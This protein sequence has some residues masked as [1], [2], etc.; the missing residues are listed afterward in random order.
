MNSV[1]C[2]TRCTKFFC[3][4]FF[5]FLFSRKTAT[6]FVLWCC[7]VFLWIVY[8]KERSIISI[9]QHLAIFHLRIKGWPIWGLWPWIS[10]FQRILKNDLSA[11]QCAWYV[12]CLKTPA[13]MIWLAN[14]VISLS[15]QIC[16]NT[17]RNLPHLMQKTCVDVS[18]KR[19]A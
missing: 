14:D 19:G 12:C 6:L 4:S 3:S 13:L 15:S 5:F 9:S 8:F 16:Q 2:F 7:S 10:V 1:V 11:K 18:A 17:T